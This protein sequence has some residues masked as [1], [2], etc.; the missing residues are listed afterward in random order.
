[1]GIDFS[2]FKNA[3]LRRQIWVLNMAFFHPG[4][5]W[6]RPNQHSYSAILHYVGSLLA[7]WLFRVGGES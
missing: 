4:S 2:T 6:F 3:A 1:M 7:A 5:L